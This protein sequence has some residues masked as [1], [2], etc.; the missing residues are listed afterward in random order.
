MRQLAENNQALLHAIPDLIFRVGRDATILDYRANS[1]DILDVPQEKII[2]SALNM[3]LDNPGAVKA[4]IERA[5]QSGQ[6]QSIRTNLKVGDATHVLEARFKSSGEEE[7]IAIIRDVSQETRLEEMK[8]EFIIRTTHELRAPIAT[9][10]LMVSLIENQPSKEEYDQYWNILKGE[11]NRERHL[12]D[13]FL[14]TGRLES[15]QFQFSLDS[16]RIDE[17]IKQVMEKLEYSARDKNISLS[18]E[19]NAE[20]AK[21]PLVVRVDKVALAQALGNLLDNAIKFTPLGGKVHIRAQK[22]DSCAQISII[23]TGIG[24]PSEDLPLLFNRFFRGSNGIEEEI[25]GVGLGLYIVRSILEKHAGSIQV[26][27][28]LGQGSQFDIWLPLEAEG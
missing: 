11:I 1:T 10:L 18:L 22:L 23:D 5:L 13:D 24:I 9:L 25:Q 26:Q 12:V 19:T 2:G 28:T 6:V 7:A 4:C 15:A 27:S 16:I 14:D 17:L 8:S 3:Y 21:T 20:E